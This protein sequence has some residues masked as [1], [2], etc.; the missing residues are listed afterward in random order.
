MVTLLDPDVFEYVVTESFPPA[1]EK[2][3]EAVEQD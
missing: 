2:L 3:I 1:P